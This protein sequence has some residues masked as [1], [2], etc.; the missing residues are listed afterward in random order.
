LL[1]RFDRENGIPSAKLD[2]KINFEGS[3]KQEKMAF[4]AAS[5]V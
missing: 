1:W 5:G 2:R 3:V 4:V